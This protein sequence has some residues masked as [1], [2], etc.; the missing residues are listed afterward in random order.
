[1]NSAVDQAWLEA[2]PAALTK[3]RGSKFRGY[4]APP[5]TGPA[6][7]SCKTCAHYTHGHNSEGRGR[8]WPKCGLMRQLWTHGPGTDIRAGSPACRKWEAKGD[9]KREVVVCDHCLQAS[10]WQGIFMCDQAREAG[11]TTRTVGELRALN[12]EDPSYWK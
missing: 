1:M 9:E 12:L 10:C 3:S 7:E 11:L 8:K 4:A 6:G 5:G 2:H